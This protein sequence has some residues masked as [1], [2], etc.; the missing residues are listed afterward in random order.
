MNSR[1][2]TPT[3]T[4]DLCVIISVRTD[5]DSERLR[6]FCACGSFV[7]GSE[8]MLWQTGYVRFRTLRDVMLYD[9]VRVC[10][11]FVQQMCTQQRDLHAHARIYARKCQSRTN[12]M[13]T[14]SSETATASL[15]RSGA[16][17]LQVAEE[18]C[19][20]HE[21]RAAGLPPGFQTSFVARNSR[22]V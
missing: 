1:T 21:R 6:Y 5:N 9:C 17:A 15:V 18:N 2:N 20:Q 14:S 10:V 4:C 16:A 22:S 8:F 3:P 12:T 11:W 19:H 7:A 13:R